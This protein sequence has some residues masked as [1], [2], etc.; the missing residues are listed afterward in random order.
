M[1]LCFCQ[2]PA[3]C[4]RFLLYIPSSR[5]KL[6]CPKPHEILL[7]APLPCYLI[8]PFCGWA[9]HLMIHRSNSKGIFFQNRP[10]FIFS[11][12]CSPVIVSVHAGCVR[13][14]ATHFSEAVLIWAALWAHLTSGFLLCR[15]LMLENK[16]FNVLSVDFIFI[17]CYIYYKGGYPCTQVMVCMWGQK[18]MSRNCFSFQHVDPSQESGQQAFT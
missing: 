17:I 13:A 4:N 7:L 8:A 11:V 15:D 10:L 3:T 5:I 2:C 6:L 1:P 16:V 12:A 14:P 18:T 9:F